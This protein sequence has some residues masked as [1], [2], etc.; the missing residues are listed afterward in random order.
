MPEDRCLSWREQAWRRIATQALREPIPV[1]MV[2]YEGWADMDDAGRPFGS[3]S[4]HFE[5]A[6][7][8]GNA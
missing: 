6:D 7:G 3:D 1:R 5:E 2:E 4:S 8:Q